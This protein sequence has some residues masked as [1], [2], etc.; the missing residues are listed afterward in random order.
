MN[1]RF[2]IGLLL[3]V[4]VTSIVVVFVNYHSMFSTHNI[5]KSADP[6]N[7]QI[8][9]KDSSDGVMVLVPNV[10]MKVAKDNKFAANN[11]SGKII[12][13]NAAITEATEASVPAKS[14]NKTGQL[15]SKVND[16]DA[17][18]HI[19]DKIEE[20]TTTATTQKVNQQVTLSIAKYTNLEDADN[21]VG[22]L[23]LLG[24]NPIINQNQKD[25]EVI[26]ITANSQEQKI[27]E[28]ELKKNNITFK[29]V[30]E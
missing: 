26:L 17:I 5:I 4:A 6:N 29:E 9:D 27:V 30:R 19:A 14:K 10:K 1:S 24:F 20:N 15:L 18:N 22:Q 13:S 16:S 25:Y 28:Q 3:G 21:M 23:T 11:A 12:A 7:Q 8:V 2:F